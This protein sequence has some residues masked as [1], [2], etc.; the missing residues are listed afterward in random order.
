[1][2]RLYWYGWGSTRLSTLDV[3]L[4]ALQADQESLADGVAAPTGAAVRVQF[5]ARWRV[6]IEAEAL[7][8]ADVFAMRALVAHLHRGGAVGFA[9]DPSKAIMAF[10]TR[11]I[12]PGQTAIATS[13]GSQFQ[14]WEP[15]AAL[16]AG[17]ALLIQGPN[18]ESAWEV[19]TFGS[20]SSLGVVTL[21]SGT[22]GAI[23]Q[24][25]IAVRPYGFWPVLTLEPGDEAEI[26]SDRELYYDLRLRLTEHPAHLAALLGQNLGTATTP[27]NSAVLQSLEQVIGR[28]PRGV[29]TFRGGLLSRG[30]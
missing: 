9:R 2:S 24:T 14:A 23:Q 29:A 21:Q 8:G 16:V 12:T 22:R 30:Q 10:I 19:N 11:P 1:M 13:G 7:A 17:D 25:P 20:V 3:H 5:G 28:A 18:P 27:T 4:S 15:A 6:T 26:I